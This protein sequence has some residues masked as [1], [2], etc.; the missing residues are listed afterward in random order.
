MIDLNSPKAK[1]IR[2]VLKACVITGCAMFFLGGCAE[3]SGLF[4]EPDGGD[5]PV[6]TLIKGVGRL[7]SPLGGGAAALSALA[8][9]GLNVAQGLLGKKK[10]A[11]KAEIDALLKAIVEGVDL[12]LDGGLKPQVLK[13]DL[14][15]SIKARLAE[16]MDDPAKAAKIIS[17]IKEELRK[18]R[19][20]K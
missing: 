16:A 18:G 7:A 10:K 14:Y 20:P 2:S 12:A 6:A 4:V 9:A 1:E 15:A 8:L 5:G 17:D 13:E 11:E 19:E 3:L